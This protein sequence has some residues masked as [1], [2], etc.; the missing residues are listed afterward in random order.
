M[1]SMR[2]SRVLKWVVAAALLCGLIFTVGCNASRQTG[3][4]PVGSEQAG[5]PNEPVV[6]T[7]P[8]TAGDANSYV[9]AD[10]SKAAVID[11]AAAGKI[12]TVLQEN[13]LEPEYIVLTHGH[14]DHISGIDA[15]RQQFPGIKVYIHPG[16][17]D[18]LPDPAK[19]LSTLVGTRVVVETEALPLDVDSRLSLGEKTFE[20]IATPGHSAGSISLKLGGVLFSGDTL[21]KGTVGRTDLPD[22]NP[23]DLAASLKKLKTLPE[24]TRI[25]PGHGEPTVLSAEKKS[26]PF[27]TVGS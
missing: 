7:I 26:N 10:G 6:Y 22:S 11:P 16:D 24:E 2:N 5:K 17:M 23:E 21:F 13:R 9:V 27:L 15:L 12:I 1:R 4:E 18:K 14:F 20:V 19:N 25:L 8:G 3:K